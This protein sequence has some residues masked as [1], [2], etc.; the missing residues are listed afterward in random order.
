MNYQANN[1]KFVLKL[2]ALFPGTANDANQLCSCL[3]KKGLQLLY[4]ARAV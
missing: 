2:W 4:I 1:F 3:I